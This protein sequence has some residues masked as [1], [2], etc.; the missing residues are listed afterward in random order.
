MEI[1]INFEVMFKVKNMYSMIKSIDI[2]RKMAKHIVLVDPSLMRSSNVV[3][4]QVKTKHMFSKLFIR[5]MK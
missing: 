1:K 2:M 5:F 4:T 3:R